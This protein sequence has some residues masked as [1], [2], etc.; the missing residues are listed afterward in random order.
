[1]PVS[2]FGEVLKTF[3]K[4]K[5]MSQRDLAARVGVHRNTIGFWEQGNYL[6]DGKSIVLELA[7][8]L[9]LNESETHQLLEA[10]LTALPP[11]WSVPSR[12][13]PF[14]TG[15]EHLL[16]QMHE[17]LCGKKVVTSPRS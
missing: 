15:R 3:R 4:R 12:R 8:H 1:M 11:Y 10:S 7:S 5:R 6:P 16:H 9:G 14:F 2:S 17:Q 13:N